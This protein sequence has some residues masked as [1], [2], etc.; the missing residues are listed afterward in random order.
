ML[1]AFMWV[2]FAAVSLLIGYAL[3][4][5]ALS[6]RSI[7]IVM[8]FGAGALISAIAYE[9]V[10]ESV[11]VGWD[12]IVA[13]ALGAL[14]FFFGDWL[15]DR[16]GGEN[17]KDIA[18]K[19]TDSSGAAIFIGTLLDN[20]PESIVLGMSIVQG[21]SISLSF[22]VA[23]FVS[24]LPEGV[25]GSIN[26]EAAGH[27]RRGIFWMW[28]ALVIVSAACAGL[29]YALIRWLPGVDGL[30]AQAF[31]AGAMLTMLADAMM[32]EAFEH[33]GMLVGLFTVL[34]FLAAAILAVIK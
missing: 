19:Q 3:S 28:L 14:A 27:S 16:R 17:R 34:G 2:G 20:V 25:A 15:V 13:F 32:P 33:G 11:L 7:G 18:G 21:G 24:N 29:G 8:G 6:N 22:L 10:P 23:V 1:S 12:I 4:A 5:R 30:Y 26:L 9:L 31:A